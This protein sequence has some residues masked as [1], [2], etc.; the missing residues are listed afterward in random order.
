MIAALLLA[1]VAKT[2]LRDSPWPKIQETLTPKIGELFFSSRY[3]LRSVD[4]RGLDL[5]RVS[6]GSKVRTTRSL[7]EKTYQRLMSGEKIKHR[8]I[9]Y[10]VAIE[11][12]V[13]LAIMSV[14]DVR[15][16]EHEYWIEKP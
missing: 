14:E 11:Q 16:D 3:R 8:K 13:L 7:T 9:S 1:L 12:G 2:P 5:E 10:T 4:D 15:D 6:T